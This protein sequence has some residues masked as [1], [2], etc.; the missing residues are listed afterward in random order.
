MRLLQKMAS[1]FL[2]RHINLKKYWFY[3]WI[4]ICWPLTGNKFVLREREGL[5][6]EETEK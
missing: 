5:N 1:A 2:C 6:E 4:L 3:L